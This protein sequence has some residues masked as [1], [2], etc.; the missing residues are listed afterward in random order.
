MPGF[1]PEKRLRTI[2]DRGLDFVDAI[3]LFDG[4]IMLTVASSWNDE[5]RYKSIALGDDGKLYSVIWTPRNGDWWLISYRRAHDGE[6]RKYG[7]HVGR[8]GEG[9]DRAG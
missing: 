2:A 7:K 6:A 1:D 8:K 4:R 9:E 3:A 5:E